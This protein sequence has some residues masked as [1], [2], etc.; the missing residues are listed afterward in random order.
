[1]IEFARRQVIAGGIGGGLALLAPVVAR[2]NGLQPIG[3]FFFDER[4]GASSAE[5]RAHRSAGIAVFDGRHDDLGRVWR[6]DMPTL[7]AG[8]SSVA[9]VTPWSDFLIAELSARELGLRLEYHRQLEE[10][11]HAWSLGR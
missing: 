10:G 11:L 1:M 7:L 2:A 6:R 3:A 8:G 9:G 4:S 5:A